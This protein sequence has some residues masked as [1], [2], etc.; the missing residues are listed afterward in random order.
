[1]HSVVSLTKVLR[2]DIEANPRDPKAWA[3]L[4]GLRICQALIGLPLGAVTSVPFVIAYRLFTEWLLGIELRPKTQI[5]PGL[6]LYHGTGLV[7]NDH[8]ILGKSVKLRHGVTIGHAQAGGPCP[9]IGDYVDIG[10]GAIIL[11]GITV[12]KGAIIAAG[13]VVVRDVP[14]GMIAVG[15]PATLRL[16]K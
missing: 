11:G 9:T 14:A 16:K 13:S 4:I 3:V 10:A 1:M 12:G 2:S 6:A 15:N 8:V 7:V 5:G